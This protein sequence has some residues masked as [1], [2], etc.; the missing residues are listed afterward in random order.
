MTTR[1]T[2]RYPGTKPFTTEQ[3]YLF[4]GRTQET[5]E[6][7]RLI[8]FQQIVVMYGKSG[9][10]KSSLLNA[11]IVPKV[12]EMKMGEFFPIRFNAWTEQAG[13]GESPRHK[14]F[15]ALALAGPTPIDAI[16]DDTLWWAAKARQLA[17][18]RGRF[19]LV[20]D[21]F[22]ELFTYPNAAVQEFK[23]Q[24]G[25]LLRAGL[26][27]RI[28]TRLSGLKIS[29]DELDLL[30]EPA[31]VKAL[32][33]IRSD[34]M[35]LLDQ[36]SD[37]LPGILQHCYELKALRP[38]DARDA[39]M[40]PAKAELKNAPADAWPFGYEPAALDNLLGFLRDEEG[41][42]EAIQL[43]TLC[44]AFEKKISGPGQ[45]ITAADTGADTLQKIIDDYYRTQLADPSLGDPNIAC[46]LI[47][48]ELVIE[49]GGGKGVRVTMHELSLLNKFADRNKNPEAEKER[50]R[51]LLDALVDLH[52]LRREVG[53]RGGDTYE[54]SH[55]RL[56][57]PVLKSRKARLETEERNR[58]AR[59]KAE[60]E[61]QLHEARAQA[62]AERQ[63]RR[64][65]NAL[66]LA[67]LLGLAF[68][69]WQY[70]DADKAKQQAEAASR[71]A[72]LA[73][74]SARIA[75]DTAE[76]RRVLADAATAR[77]KH[78]QEMAERRLVD[79]KKAEAAR[80]TAEGDKRKTV[81]ARLFNEAD[82]Y[83]RAKLYKNALAKLDE[84]LNIDPMNTEALRKR[85][86]I[87]L[88]E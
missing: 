1:K 84:V 12:A 38:S 21:Q 22:E 17:G 73:G 5:G 78:A 11:G 3:E 31:D 53:S 42:I 64:R 8:R 40:L 16:A 55:D 45:R 74:D 46:R 26:P 65:S 15:A 59:E 77:A 27:Q 33:V 63:R 32:F 23:A 4:H 70:R 19:L 51:H 41:R 24:L 57:E 6:L 87:E 58:I 28:E 50:L 44:Q 48:D 43:Q 76:A 83:A 54:L 56:I 72:I 18:G 25:E 88:R 34:R 52:L 62:A 49:T 35:H 29:E 81:I 67:A 39:I 36:L 60:T 30:Y 86:E 2:Y 71:R 68:A 10:G 61:R 85:R 14:T 80:F 13:P 82:I 9:L 66:A 69:V 37:L 20:F 79:F 75:R 7:L 47:E